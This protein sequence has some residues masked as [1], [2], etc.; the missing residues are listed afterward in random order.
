MA[1]ESI[2]GWGGKRPGAG[3]GTAIPAGAG[4]K[5]RITIAL[6]AEVLDALRAQWPGLSDQDLVRAACWAAMGRPVVPG[7]PHAV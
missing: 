5:T 7:K 1:Q 3:M 2:K 4:D 6:G